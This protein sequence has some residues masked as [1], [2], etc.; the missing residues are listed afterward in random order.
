GIS[1]FKIGRDQLEVLGGMCCFLSADYIQSSDPYV[2]EKLKQCEDLSAQQISALESV[3]LG[4]N[5]SYGYE[6]TH[7]RTVTLVSC[8]LYELRLTPDLPLRPSDSWNRTTLENLG[9]LPLYL[10]TN[11]W[12]KFSQTN[13]QRFL[14]TFIRDLRKNDKAS[15]MKIL[16]MMNEV[17]KISRVKIKRSA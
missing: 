11:I 4:G 1:G 7:T 9:L 14:K 17:N 2:L 8:P 13:K 10:T 15:E 5:T 3:L 6:L 12:G 16:S